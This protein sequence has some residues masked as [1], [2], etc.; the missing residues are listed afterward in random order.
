MAAEVSLMPVEVMPIA[1]H[2]K[3]PNA[4]AK[5]RQH[6]FDFEAANELRFREYWRANRPQL[7]RSPPG[8][9]KARME[10]LRARVVAREAASRSDLG[11]V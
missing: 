5:M 2:A 4:T 3:R 7:K 1:S 10:A 6:A 8:D 11:Y 9:A